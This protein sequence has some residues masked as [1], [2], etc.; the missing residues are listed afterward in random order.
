M[1]DWVRCLY[2][3][4]DLVSG[5][6]NVY[7]KCL[8]KK[9]SVAHLWRDGQLLL[10]VSSNMFLPKKPCAITCAS[11]VWDGIQWIIVEIKLGTKS[12]VKFRLNYC[13]FSPPC[14][15]KISGLANLS[16][17]GI[18]CTVIV[19]RNQ[20]RSMKVWKMMVILIQR[21]KNFSETVFWMKNLL[22]F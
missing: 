19:C 16:K 18:G 8:N 14:E 13:N 11:S 21:W 15:V 9:H 3:S 2:Q 7:S 10:Y 4:E 17:W 1:Q 20:K 12:S 5:D 6:E 22:M